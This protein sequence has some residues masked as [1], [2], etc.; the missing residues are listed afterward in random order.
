[1]RS[2]GDIKIWSHETVNILTLGAGICLVIVY[3][4]RKSPMVWGDWLVGLITGL[5][6]ARAVW[7]CIRNEKTEHGDKLGTFGLML[8]IAR[9][10]GIVIGGFAILAGLVLAYNWLCFW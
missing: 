8:G 2:A 4:L 1:M 3:G 6:L 10:A 9:R 5:A 7:L